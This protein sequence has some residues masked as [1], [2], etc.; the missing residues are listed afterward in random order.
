MTV[1]R[2]LTTE[3]G[4][5][6]PAIHMNTPTGLTMMCVD[7]TGAADPDGGDK[8]CMQ[9]LLSH[10]NIKL[11]NFKSSLIETVIQLYYFRAFGVIVFAWLFYRHKFFQLLRVFFF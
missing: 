7:H 9:R 2:V 5:D 10:V 6:R 11:I 4:A 3:G 1:I 8:L